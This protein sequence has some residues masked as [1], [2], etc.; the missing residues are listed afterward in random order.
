MIFNSK[1]GV[2]KHVCGCEVTAE[3]EEQL[4]SCFCGLGFP[5]SSF[6]LCSK[7]SLFVLSLVCFFGLLVTVWG[8]AKAGIR[9]TNVQI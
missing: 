4:N 9:S 1:V 5:F 7:N 3:G 6:S 8:F 2:K